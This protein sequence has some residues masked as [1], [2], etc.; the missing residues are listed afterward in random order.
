MRRKLTLAEILACKVDGIQ[1]MAPSQHLQLHIRSR[2][3]ADHCN[4]CHRS[5]LADLPCF[6]RMKR[7]VEHLYIFSTGVPSSGVE[8][9]S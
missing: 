7:I 4:E 5:V 2:R 3:S 1:S 6:A 9:M 8:S